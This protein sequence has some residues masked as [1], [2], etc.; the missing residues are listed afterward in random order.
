MVE[1]L[2]AALLTDEEF[3]KGRESWKEL[4]DPIFDGAKLWELKD[5]IAYGEGD[6]DDEED[7][8]EDEDC[9]DCD[10]VSE[11]VEALRLE[12]NGTV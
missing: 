3:S 9:D 2:N 1:A 12:S 7:E 8:C 6:E 5:L 4:D 10:E 11:S